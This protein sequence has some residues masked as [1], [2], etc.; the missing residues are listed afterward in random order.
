MEKNRFLKIHFIYQGKLAGN[1]YEVNPYLYWW[2]STIRNVKNGTARSPI[3][4]LNEENQISSKMIVNVP[5]SNS[6][7]YQLD[8]NI[9]TECIVH[10]PSQE[11]KYVGS[12][13]GALHVTLKDIYDQI[14]E[15]GKWKRKRNDLLMNQMKTDHGQPYKKGELIKMKILLHE[16]PFIKNWKFPSNSP[17]PYDIVPKN[18]Q[19]LSKVLN[20]SVMS[21]LFPYTDTAG[22]MNLQFQPSVS[23]IE[24]I[25]APLWVSNIE[26]PGWCYWID[27]SDYEPDEPFM[28]NLASVALDRYGINRNQFLHIADK[29][30]QT[31]SDNYDEDF[32]TVV[33]VT[34][35]ACAIL[36]IS[37]YYKSDESYSVEKERSFF[38]FQNNTPTIRKKSIESF[39]DALLMLGDDCEGLGVLIHRVMRIMAPMPPEIAQTLQPPK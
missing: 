7:T 26:V 14:L 28:T 4:F 29:Q 24:S 5:I 39:N 22:K 1:P 10:S 9:W 17:G 16:N 12:R 23:R 8:D 27:Y 11:G 18:G 32:H 19:F 20:M 37:L 34:M 38:I 30:L 35:N 21:A 31:I 36:S 6:D 15:N 33:A 3:K 13:A 25:H 2:S